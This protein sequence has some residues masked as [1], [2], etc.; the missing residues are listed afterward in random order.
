MRASLIAN[1][2]FGLWFRWRGI[3]YDRGHCP[4]SP[5]TQE[6][7]ATVLSEPSWITHSILDKL[8]NQYSTLTSHA[9]YVGPSLVLIIT[10]C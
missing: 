2:F 3:R 6:G 7:H 9:A 1:S 10:S 4:F 8:D 5:F